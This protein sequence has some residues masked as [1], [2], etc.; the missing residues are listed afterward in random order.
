MQEI[1]LALP[2]EHA[3]MWPLVI[4]TATILVWATILCHW[5][6]KLGLAHHN[7]I[8]NVAWVWP[9]KPKSGMPLC[10]MRGKVSPYN[11]LKSSVSSGLG[12][13]LI[14]SP[15]SLPVIDSAPETL[16]LCYSSTHRYAPCALSSYLGFPR[17]LFFPD[18]FL[19]ASLTSFRFLFTSHFCNNAHTDH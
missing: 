15:P 14:F 18:F 6:T 16:C 12:H 17:R 10:S 13:S 19:D 9:L 4:S 8:L 11:G 3:R 7:L 5:I 1:L 2:S